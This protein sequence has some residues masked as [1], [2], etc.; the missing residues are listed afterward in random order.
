MTE[1]SLKDNF[2]AELVY[3]EDSLIC[4]QETTT[5]VYHSKGKSK[6]FR[7]EGYIPKLAPGE[8][9]LLELKA[10]T[11]QT[12]GVKQLQHYTSSGVKTL[13]DGATLKWFLEGKKNSV[14]TEKIVITV[15]PIARR[16]IK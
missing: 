7:I 8:T 1:V 15:M 10:K 13:N 9:A 3:V 5:S 12:P 14:K 11:G 4:G 16:R 6:Q 2:P